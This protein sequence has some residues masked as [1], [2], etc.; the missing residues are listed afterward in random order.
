MPGDILVLAEQR[1]QELDNITYELL[2]K[3]REIA[4]RLGVKLKIMITGHGLDKQVK[5]LVGS[6][7]DLILVADDI[8]LKDYNPVIY[9]KQISDTIRDTQPQLVIMGHFFLGIEMGPAVATVT[10]ATLLSNCIDLEFTG[11]KLVVTHP[12]YGGTVHIKMEISG[13][14]PYI[15]SFEK[16]VLPRRSLRS[17]HASVLPLPVK[18][19]GLKVLSRVIDRQEAIAGEVDL[20]KAEV[21]VSLGRGIGDRENIQLGRD[22]AAALG[23]AIGCSRHLSDSGWLPPECHVGMEGKTVAPK[24]YIA[25][26]ISGASHHVGGIRDSDLIIAIN[27]DPYAPIFNVAHYGV[28]GDVLAV[29]PGLTEAALKS[30]GLSKRQIQYKTP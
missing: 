8:S 9:C 16:G 14:L 2:A 26:G 12:T 5:A 27:H 28:V 6:G 30:P 29:L 23:G 21:I 13:P 1:E 15:I 24:V 11:D 20:A 19:A 4:E 22:L 3:G 17:T 10:G 25:C 7:A 18:N